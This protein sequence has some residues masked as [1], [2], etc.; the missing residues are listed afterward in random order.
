MTNTS[1]ILGKRRGRP[2]KIEAT[3]N[4]ASRKASALKQ[5]EFIDNTDNESR[6]FNKRKIKLPGKQ[7]DLTTYDLICSQDVTT[8]KDDNDGTDQNEKV[9]RILE[10]TKP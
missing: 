5:G 10:D 2:P 1:S 3:N 4:Q 6:K 7:K 9:R 8:R